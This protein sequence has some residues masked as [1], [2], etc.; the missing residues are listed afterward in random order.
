[1]LPLQ[2]ELP[3][4]MLCRAHGA[5]A[6]YTPMLHSRLFLEQ[7]KYR[8]E[9]FSTCPG[10]RPLFIQ[11]CANDPDTFV[12]A[13]QIVQVRRGLQLPLKPAI[14]PAAVAGSTKGRC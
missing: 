9:H 7:H 8:E 6:A 2:S 14:S 1:M 12:A 4:R 13:A 10:D 3:F 11:F 5:E